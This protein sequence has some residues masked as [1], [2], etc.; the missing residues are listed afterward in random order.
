MKMESKL[1]GCLV[2]RDFLFDVNKDAND[3]ILLHCYYCKNCSACA[4]DSRLQKELKEI[5][6][7]L[8]TNILSGGRFILLMRYL[9]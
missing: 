3:W 9:F 6:L 5:I 4:I 1:S 8:K 7:R 2:L